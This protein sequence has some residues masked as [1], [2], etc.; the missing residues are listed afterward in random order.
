MGEDENDGG[1]DTDAAD[2]DGADVAEADNGWMCTSISI[3]VYVYKSVLLYTLR[4]G[5]I[6]YDTI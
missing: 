4:Y 1:Y 2:A 3:H 5:P 6:R